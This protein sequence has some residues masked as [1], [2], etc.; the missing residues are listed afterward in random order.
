M[1]RYA[2]LLLIV[3]MGL[4]SVVEPC[5]A[6]AQRP[7]KI[8]RIGFLISETLSAQASR[9]AAV[10]AGLRDRGYVEGKNVIIEIR[11]A[12][13][14]YDRLPGLAAELIRANVDVFVVVGAKAVVAAKSATTT[15]PIVAPAIGDPV[16]LG[17]SGSLGRPS[18][19]VTGTSN[20]GPEVSVKRLE[21]L[22]E[23]SPRIAH[24]A[25]LLN[26]ANA[27]N[28]IYFQSMQVAATSLKLELQ[29][30]DVL[31]AKDLEKTFSAFAARH[32]DALV[33]SPDTLFRANANE[34]AARAA[35]Q[36]IPS[37]GPTEYAE[38]DLLIGYGASNDEMYRRAAY[39][40]D[41]LFRGAKPID[42]P[43]EGATK[44]ELVINLKTAK[45]LG[46]T[47]PQSL[48]L[49]ADEVIQ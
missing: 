47:I 36:R 11:S 5:S 12:D 44:F 10:R 1:L 30:F 31:A 42:L 14:N 8:Y 40:V 7:G 6:E 2:V 17:L 48:L 24:V 4:C 18:G 9:V 33:V 29:P 49:R 39:L 22:K 43:I 3:L 41:R 34:I 38:G 37:S 27:S 32:I 35:R 45:A 19:N 23:A 25:V 15:I 13:G 21:L 16:A 20:F 26:P 28:R 46:L